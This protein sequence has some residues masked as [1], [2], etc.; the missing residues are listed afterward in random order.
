MRYSDLKII[1]EVVSGELLPSEVSPMLFKSLCEIVLNMRK[2]A[3]AKGVVCEG[4]GYCNEDDADADFE[5]M[6]QY[7]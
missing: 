7:D 4:C 2:Q 1:E 3:I 5:M 6:S